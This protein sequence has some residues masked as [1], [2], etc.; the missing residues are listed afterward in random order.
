MDDVPK[1]EWFNF[2]LYARLDDVPADDGGEA[3]VRTWINNKLLVEQTAIQTLSDATTE[4]LAVYFFTYWNGG[5]PK[6]QHLFVDNILITNEEPSKFDLLGNP[7]LGVA[8]NAAAPPTQFNGTVI[9]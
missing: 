1:G 6:D 9:K 8:V 7:F 5:A 4:M 3:L 2:E